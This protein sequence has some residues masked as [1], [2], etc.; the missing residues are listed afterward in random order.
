MGRL[1]DEAPC[2]PPP[3]AA[4]DR[5]PPG[6]KVVKGANRRYLVVP[7]GNLVDE[8]YTVYFTVHEPPKKLNKAAE[9]EKE[10]AQAFLT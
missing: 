7:L 6:S 9:T 5:Y 10:Y 8:R 1:T 2:P 3:P 4:T